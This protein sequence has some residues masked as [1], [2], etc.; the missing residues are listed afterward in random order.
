[1]QTILWAVESMRSMR[2]EKIV[3]AGEF[4]ELFGAFLAQVDE[5]NLQARVIMESRWKV[6]PRDQNRGATFVAQSVIKQNLWQSYMASGH[7]GW[8]FELFVNES[9]GL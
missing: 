8:L 7:P 1:M 6:V 2:L 9:R 3:F 5:I 4:V